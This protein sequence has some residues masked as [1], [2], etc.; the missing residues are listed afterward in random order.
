MA[1]KSVR[2]S[3]VLSGSMNSLRAEWRLVGLDVSDYLATA[4]NWIWRTTLDRS[5]R[6][7]AFP[8]E[9]SSPQARASPSVAIV[10][11][12]ESLA[13]DQQKSEGSPSNISHT[14]YHYIPHR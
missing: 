6:P 4:V 3:L 10:V 1:K 12:V 5:G 14:I 7:S 11:G 9:V 8:A 13:L 2:G